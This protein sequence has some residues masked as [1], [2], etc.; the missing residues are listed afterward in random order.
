MTTVG[1]HLRRLRD[2]RSPVLIAEA[3]ARE[4]RI[5]GGA[6]LTRAQLA[7]AGKTGAPV[8]VGPFMGEVGFE[9]LYW[10]PFLRSILGGHGIDPARVTAISRGGAE[11]W[12]RGIADGY[13]DLF[14]LY[15]PEEYRQRL[16]ERRREAG[17][18]KQLVE[19]AFDREVLARAPRAHGG[20][21]VVLHPSLL[22]S[23]LRYFW[24]GERPLETVL[25]SASYARLEPPDRPAGLP[26]APYVVVKPYFSSCLPDTAANRT[27]LRDLVGE[28]A[29]G[30]EVVLLPS[31]FDFDDHDA[32]SAED[33]PGV[34]PL[35]AAEGP[36][37]NLAVQTA[38]IAGAQALVGTYGGFSYL[39]PLLGVPSAT[40]FSERN[41]NPAHVEVL[42]VAAGRLK[43]DWRVEHTA[44][45]SQA[46]VSASVWS[47]RDR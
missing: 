4:M 32:L 39:A 16:K 29:K 24:A 17:D 20:E 5:R 2:R 7:R 13:V 26:D 21:P 33:L 38:A 45:A 3:V 18:S 27:Y 9:L 12:Y 14:D 15:S 35:P 47:N 10:I 31:S 22:F 46:A 23:R 44:D 19:L 6:R 36:R 41:F 42:R 37:T 43:S 30:G 25:D 34:W 40:V 8:V 28:L 11:S 1:P